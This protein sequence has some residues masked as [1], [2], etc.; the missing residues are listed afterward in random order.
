M[1]LVRVYLAVCVVLI[2][3]KLNLPFTAGHFAVQLFFIISGFYMALVLN[4]KYTEANPTRFYLARYF[5]LWPTYIVVLLF[6]I[7]FLRPFP[8]FPGDLWTKAYFY[9]SAFSL[10]GHDTLWLALPTK[11]GL[12]LST[13]VRNG[14]VLAGVTGMQQ[15][16]SVG[17]ELV[18][19]ALAP[20]CARNWRAI[21]AL[22]VMAFG[23]HLWLTMTLDRESPILLRLPFDFFWLFLAGML[24]YWAWR[25]VRPQLDAVPL[26]AIAV[27]IPAVI[28]TAGMIYSRRYLKDDVILLAFAVLLIPYYHY[29]QKAAWDRAIGELSYPIYVAHWP[30][31]VHFLPT[32]DVRLS[33]IVVGLTAAASIALHLFVVRP[34]DAWRT[35]IPQKIA[36]ARAEA[37]PAE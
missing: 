35:R 30:L 34:I 28:I 11:E 15:M 12:T 14:H 25:R 13:S 9:F 36:K 5:R 22:A 7:T 31:I 6:A 29:T 18:F 37:A 2:H 23:V 19:Y 1:G 24:G 26:P 16:W 8:A 32:G 4:E 27:A 10:L 21:L 3:C 20:L 17:V 33:L